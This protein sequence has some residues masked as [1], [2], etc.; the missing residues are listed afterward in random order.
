[1]PR[2]VIGPNF[3]FST[4]FSIAWFCPLQAKPFKGCPRAQRVLAAVFSATPGPK[5]RH[6]GRRLPLLGGQVELASSA[7]Q[8][9]QGPPKLDWPAASRAF[10]PY[11][12]PART[13]LMGPCQMSATSLL[14]SGRARVQSA[15]CA[16]APIK[17][18]LPAGEPVDGQTE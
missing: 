10:L 18:G 14:T 17:E 15:A 7:L 1:M 11:P 16:P 4:P 8:S 3:Y 12:D 5:G 6:R 2:P 13:I 9:G